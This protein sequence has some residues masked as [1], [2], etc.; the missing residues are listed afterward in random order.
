MPSND[1]EGEGES[2]GSTRHGTHVRGCPRRT[3]PQARGVGR[4]DVQAKHTGEH[5]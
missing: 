4:V 3:V 1:A 2:C 5:P